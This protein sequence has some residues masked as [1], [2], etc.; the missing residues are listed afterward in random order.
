MEDAMDYS[1]KVAMN[2]LRFR[3]HHDVLYE[4][5]GNVPPDFLVDRRI[6]VEVRRL[7]QTDSGFEPRKALEE[8]SIPLSIRFGRLLASYVAAGRVVALPRR[9][10]V[11]K[12]F[13]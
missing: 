13:Q 6:A 9:I 8:S 2:H 1:E 5:D 7:G 10:P 12:A 3:G 11:G 4:P